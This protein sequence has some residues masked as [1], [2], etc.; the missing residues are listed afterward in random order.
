MGIAQYRNYL[1]VISGFNIL[2]YKL[3]DD[4][5]NKIE[6]S[7]LMYENDVITLPKRTTY[8]YG[9]SMPNG[10]VAD[11]KGILYIADETFTAS[12]RIWCVDITKQNPTAEVWLKTSGIKGV[13]S[14][15]GMAIYNKTIYFTDY[16]ILRGTTAV[17]KVRINESTGAPEEVY[18]LYERLGAPATFF[19]DLSAGKYEYSP[20]EYVEGVYVADFMQGTV[21][22]IQDPE[23]DVDND[24]IKQYETPYASYAAPT[25]VVRGVAPFFS[26]NLLIVSEKFSNMISSVEISPKK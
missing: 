4:Y 5:S 17:K 16:N 25:K 11:A 1:Y 9:L 6:A 24:G 2:K 20:G 3:T 23:G 15:N 10:M 12:G 19:D 26:N 22:F 8:K 13:N 7:S 14:P 21:I 18:V